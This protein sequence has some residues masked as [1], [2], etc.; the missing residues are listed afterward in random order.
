[1]S[2]FNRKVDETASR[3]N[4]GVSEAA[5]RLEK[6][7]ADFIAYLNNEVVPAVRNQSS[8]ALRIAAQKLHDL[9]NFMDENRKKP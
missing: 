3:V 8:K 2:D 7:S 9:A 1:M 4:K 6:E 5:E